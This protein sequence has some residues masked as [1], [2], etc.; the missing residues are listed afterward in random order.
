MWA[1]VRAVISWLCGVHFVNS[2]VF[3][4]GADATGRPPPFNP[5][6]IPSVSV[7]TE[8]R[9][10]A[11]P[12]QTKFVCPVK[13]GL[14]CRCKWFDCHSLALALLLFFMFSVLAFVIGSLCFVVVHGPYPAHNQN[15]S[16]ANSTRDGT[17]A[18]LGFSFLY[19]VV[20][21]VGVFLVTLACTICCTGRNLLPC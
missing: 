21:L 19:G 10:D 3:V 15:G 1:W 2:R 16:F 11:V 6:V 9:A 18:P 13:M 12:C 4:G 7:L 20:L 17:R 14:R 5:A 8:S